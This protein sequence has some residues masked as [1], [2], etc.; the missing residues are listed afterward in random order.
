VILPPLVFPGPSIAHLNVIHDLGLEECLGSI[1]HD[2]V[3]ELGLGN[4]LAELVEMP[5]HFFLFVTGQIS[6][7]QCCK[8]YYVRNLLMF[9]IC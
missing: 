3:A 4:V 2:F 1:V 9:V 7:A 5:Q 6:W 8:N